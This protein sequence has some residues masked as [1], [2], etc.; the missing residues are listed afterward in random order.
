MSHKSRQKTEQKNSWYSSGPAP[1]PRQSLA[2]QSPRSSE[3]QSRG[4]AENPLATNPRIM[5]ARMTA[6]EPVL[7]AK[8]K[9][10]TRFLHLCS[11]ILMSPRN[12]VLAT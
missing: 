8:S 4:K 11:T 6:R 5:S 2:G 7:A 1:L 3:T 12:Q 9:V 10:V